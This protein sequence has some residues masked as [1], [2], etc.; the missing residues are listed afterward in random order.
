M[1]TFFFMQSFV[2]FIYQNS[3]EPIK[4]QRLFILKDVFIETVWVFAS[5]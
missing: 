5:V 2:V 4:L 1:F 3:N